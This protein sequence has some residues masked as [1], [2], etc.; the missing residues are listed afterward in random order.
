M[1][2]IPPLGTYYAVWT[3]A[4]S[5]GAATMGIAFLMIQ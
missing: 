1:K 2:F 3:G 4:G 5:I